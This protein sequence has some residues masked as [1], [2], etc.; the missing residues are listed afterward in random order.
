[1][2]RDES[3]DTPKINDIPPSVPSSTPSVPHQFMG[4]PVYADVLIA[5]AGLGGLFALFLK[6]RCHTNC[7]RDCKCGEYACCCDCGDCGCC[8]CNC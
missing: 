3:S 2:A 5:F 4:L 6:F 7:P 1:M 8:N